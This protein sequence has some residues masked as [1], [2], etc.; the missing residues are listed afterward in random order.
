MV[1]EQ[2]RR[3]RR[4]L[5]LIEHQGALDAVDV[6]VQRV[7]GISRVHVPQDHGAVVAAREDHLLTR[8][9]TRRSEG[10]RWMRVQVLALRLRL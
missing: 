4:I 9:K 6:T 10:S 8:E 7:Q 5:D 1:V 2:G 3:R